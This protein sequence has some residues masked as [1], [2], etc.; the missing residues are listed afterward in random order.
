MRPRLAVGCALVLA[1]AAPG[2]A[3]DDFEP[4]PSLAELSADEAYARRS[5]RSLRTAGFDA[6]LAI[7]LDGAGRVLVAG[8][9]GHARRV[10]RLEVDGRLD[11]TFGAAGVAEVPVLMRLDERRVGLEVDAA[12]RIVVTGPFYRPGQILTAGP[13]YGAARLLD[14][15]SLDPDF[16]GDGLL[17]LAP[18]TGINFAGPV[19][20]SGSDGAMLVLNGIGLVRIAADGTIDAT[21][22]DGGFARI[23]QGPLADTID[24]AVHSVTDFAVDSAGRA[25]VAVWDGDTSGFTVRLDDAGGLDPSFWTPSYDWPSNFTASRLALDG[26][27]RII[28][29]DSFGVF[30]RLPDG[31]RDRT[32]SG[33]GFAWS[34]E[35]AGFPGGVWVYLKL[36]A[37]LRY[38]PHYDPRRET[39]LLA[40]ATRADR[41]VIATTVPNVGTRVQ[42]IDPD[43]PGAIVRTT[44]D[45]RLG[46]GVGIA[47]ASD[48]TSAYALGT[49]CVVRVDLTAPK[50][51][52]LPDLR[53]KWLGFPH[54]VDLGGGR[55]RVTANLRIRNASRCDV[56]VAY[57]RVGFELDADDAP[58]DVASRWAAGPWR[59]FR[60]RGRGSVVKRFTWEGGNTKTDLAGKRL[61]VQV[62][63]ELPD[64]NAADNVA[65]SEP[66]TPLYAPR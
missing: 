39:G 1:A 2:F 30:R 21:Y 60:V 19:H 49:A 41:W 22:G 37:L 34:L 14:D 48:G 61:S 59:P 50:A 47:I 54:A 13:H 5:A 52:P 40:V 29:L 43:D 3:Q 20:A 53:A 11:P 46:G 12:G 45:R 15:G 26:A 10:A 33:D 44:L 17:E 24:W 42:M 32:F 27:G 6:A 65:T 38:D 31:A 28:G 23:A 35:A 55:Y 8:T 51:L 4:H 18:A 66:M 62:A 58:L 16:S 63:C 7:R 36:L 56:A 64:A 25:L 57:G 9:S